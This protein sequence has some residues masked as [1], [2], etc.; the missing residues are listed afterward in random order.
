VLLISHDRA[1]LEA[2]GSRTIVI[3]GGGL[4][5]HP[6]GWAEYRAGVEAERAASAPAPAKKARM[7]RQ[8]GPSKNSRAALAKLEREVERA[9]AE[10]RRL[11]DELADPSHWAD[12]KRAAKSSERHERARERLAELMARW[13]KAAEKVER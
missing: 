12:P 13:E 1:L 7:P 3:E 2:V 6:G 8:P 11:E 10:V 9:E 5:S 4:H